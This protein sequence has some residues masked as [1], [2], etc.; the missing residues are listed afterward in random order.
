MSVYGK[1]IGLA[2]LLQIVSSTSSASPFLFIRCVQPPYVLLL[3]MN[4]H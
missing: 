4:P 2:L 1:D 3:S